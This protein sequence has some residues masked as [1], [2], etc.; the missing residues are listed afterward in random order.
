MNTPRRSHCIPGLT[1]AAWAVVFV[2]VAQSAEPS[3]T[4]DL[5]DGVKIELIR[6]EPGT[7][8]QGSAA[9]RPGRGEDET[10]REVTISQA[11][12]I[13][14]TPVTRGQF[15]QFVTATKYR[16]EAEKGTSGGFGLENGAL[17]Q[18]TGYNWRNPGF[19]QTDDHPV[20][21]VTWDDTQAFARWLSGKK[22]QRGP[23][24]RRF[25][26]G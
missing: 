14:K 21:L 19:K 2:G 25:S 5:G 11:Y 16:T 8:M 4:L 22:V 10:E 12:Y 7:F 9:G 23:R 13:G 15:A 20:V 24:T 3:R 17:V 26:P 18:K 1:L 6:I